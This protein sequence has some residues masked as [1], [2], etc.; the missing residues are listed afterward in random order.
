MYIH[1]LHVLRHIRHIALLFIHASVDASYLV[2]FLRYYAWS[3]KTIEIF[4]ICVFPNDSCI[5]TESKVFSILLRFIMSN[6]LQYWIQ[7]DCSNK[8]KYEQS[9]TGHTDCSYPNKQSFY[10]SRLLISHDQSSFRQNL[11]WV[12]ILKLNHG[13][14]TKQTWFKKDIKVCPLHGEASFTVEHI[15]QQ[16]SLLLFSCGVNGP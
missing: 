14:A 1:A 7:K 4:D 8:K 11:S 9:K 3:W 10:M 12:P 6:E 2:E 5:R 16:K 13:R 15:T